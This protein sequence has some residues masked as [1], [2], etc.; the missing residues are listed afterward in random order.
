MFGA[1]FGH[2]CY[3]RFLQG[4]LTEVVDASYGRLHATSPDW[5]AA[6][7][8]PNTAISHALVFASMLA[9][10]TAGLAIVLLA[11]PRSTGADLTYGL[12]V[13]L[14]AA[15][16]SL[17]CGGVWA[18]AGTEV[19]KVLLRRDN[20]LAFKDDLL[21]RQHG[22]VVG[23]WE[24]PEFG[25]LDREVYEPDWQE[26]RYPDLRGMSRDDQ[27]RILYNKMVCDAIIGVQRGL[28]YFIPLYFI[29]MMVVP[30]L[31]AVAAGSLWR[32]YRRPWPLTI[33]YVE[34]IVPIVFT[35]S[36][37]G[38]VVMAAAVLRAMCGADW[39]GFYESVFWPLQVALA[40][41]IVP[42]VAVRCGWPVWL[43]LL[44][45]AG[46]IVFVVYARLRLGSVPTLANVLR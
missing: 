1:L 28:M 5:L 36:L 46:W 18:F 42:Q 17:M 26:R 31:E 19:L 30:G 34:R 37:G 45:H 29:V 43:R 12:A 21:Q 3:F 23:A 40:L 38:A 4:P 6:L 9:G 39:F 15:Q 7:A 33:A 10:T 16:V 25:E 44:L 11:R 35:L 13:G 2:M 32:R 27:R 24:L 14:V 41:V 22:P 20:V 8:K